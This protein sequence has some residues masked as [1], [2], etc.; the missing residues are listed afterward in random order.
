MSV[1]RV[2]RRLQRRNPP[3]DQLVEQ[4][5]GDEVA[6]KSGRNSPSPTSAAA[7]HQVPLIGNRPRGAPIELLLDGRR[8]HHISVR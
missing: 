3:H 1:D 2:E 8:R 5:Y 7:N 6:P 4:Q